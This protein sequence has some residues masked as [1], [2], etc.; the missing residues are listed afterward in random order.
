MREEDIGA[1]RGTKWRTRDL[2]FRD[3]CVQQLAAIRFDKIEENACGQL[4]MAGRPC[5]EKEQR[6]FVANHIRALLFTKQVISIF[7]LR[8]KVFAN[9]RPDLVAAAVNA[10]TD[11]SPNILRLRSEMAVHFADTFLHDAL[12][13]AS[14]PG[15]KHADGS[16][17][18]VGE[19]DGNTVSSEDAQEDARFVGDHAVASKRMPGRIVNRMHDVGVNLTKDDE[20]RAL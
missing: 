19:D 5:G 15:M 14:P 4:A 10:R 9:F 20:P 2:F 12:D 17:F 11:G 18:F 16:P 1:T 3:P 13:G 6:I 8:L 7:K